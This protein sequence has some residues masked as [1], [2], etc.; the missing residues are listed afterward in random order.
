MS[1]VLRVFPPEGLPAER[2]DAVVAAQRNAYADCLRTIRKTRDMYRKKAR[3]AQFSTER[4]SHDG[5]VT[6]RA[7]YLLRFH[8]RLWAPK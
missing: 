8:V 5:D 7:A 4:I 3:L 1:V 6:Q 2:F